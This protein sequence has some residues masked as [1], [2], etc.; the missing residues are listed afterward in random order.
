MPFKIRYSNNNEDKNG[1]VLMKIQK[2]YQLL[3]LV[4]F[5]SGVIEASS[6]FGQFGGRAFQ[7]VATPTQLQGFFVPKAQ[8][9]KVV[10]QVE[11]QA[12]G[13]F[14]KPNQMFSEQMKK[15]M[16]NPLF[17]KGA[18]AMGLVGAGTAYQ[19]LTYGA[20]QLQKP[21]VTAGM[22][23]SL[24]QSE[25]ILQPKDI[26]TQQ[27]VQQDVKMLI[28]DSK[29]W[30]NMSPADMVQNIK[31]SKTM[32]TRIKEYLDPVALRSLVSTLLSSVSQAM[33][34]LN[35]RTRSFSRA[36]QADLGKQAQER[37][38]EKFFA[39]R[40]KENKVREKYAK[41]REAEEAAKTSLQRY[42]EMLRNTALDT[43]GR[44]TGHW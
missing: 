19:G 13:K 20:G 23:K 30:E 36:K 32:F 9:G 34:M 27:E 16:S 7:K 11:Q 44:L 8:M 2:V 14:F 24:P 5:A 28:S 3:L 26:L 41:K 40:D 10:G 31:E 6:K 12:G 25:P 38:Y 18:G 15:Q 35:M 33:D 21:M 29:N 37:D 1:G 4:M 42:Y 22:F 39:Q 43:K 17:L